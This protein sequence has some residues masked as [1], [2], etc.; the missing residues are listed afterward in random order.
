V[1]KK[2]KQATATRRSSMK[3]AR[4]ANATL[5]YQQ[6]AAAGTNGLSK[7]AKAAKRKRAGAVTTTKHFENY[8]GNHGC[9]RCVPMLN[10]PAY[11]H[12]G[13]FL[14]QRRFEKKSPPWKTSKEKL[15]FKNRE[16]AASR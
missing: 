10:S 8:C 15:A 6:R 14:Y 5:L 4:R 1:S 12:P 11:A 9:I 3:K 16:R 13:S 7:R 2:S